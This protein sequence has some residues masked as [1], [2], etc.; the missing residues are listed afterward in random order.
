MARIEAAPE[1]F[2]DFDRIFDH[3]ARLDVA[4]APSRIE[5]I[6]QAVQILSSSPLI[7]RPVKAGKRELVIGRDSRGHVA[8]YRYIPAV[9]TV[10]L[11]AIRNQREAGY[12]REL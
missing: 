12:A 4:A 3:L 2:D 11:L 8:L 6:L 7:G 5:A 10:F 1:L 9:D